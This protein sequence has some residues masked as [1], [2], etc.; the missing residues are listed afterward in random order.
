M[1]ATA[2][3]RQRVRPDIVHIPDGFLDAKT[4]LASA[5]LSCAGLSLAVRAVQ[6]RLPPARVPLL[7]LSTAF[8]FAAQMVNFPVVGGTSGHLLG[9]VLVTVLLGP[10][11][12]VLVMSAVLIL[13]C[14]L[15]ADGGLTALGA[16]LFNMALVAP[17]VGHGVNR[18][19][20][21]L[22]G[23]GLRARLFAAAF[24]A[25]C[26]T[27]AAAISCA[28]QLAMSGT[29]PWRATFPAMALIHML[30]GAGEAI[31]TALVLSGLARARP[32]L[33]TSAA[34]T[35]GG[36]RS[37]VA[38]GLLGSIG[39][40]VFVAPF[41]CPWP[42]GL[43]KVAAVLGFEH[44]AAER[45]ILS[46][47]LPNYTVPGLASQGGGTVIA[48]GVGTLAAFALTWW[49]ARRLTRGQRGTV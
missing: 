27:V 8:V 6:R 35:P 28:G 45:P 23:T 18:S 33:L 19:V 16:N 24:A 39:L 22:W 48:G 7:G 42:D 32:E 47:P 34:E 25:W 13:Q 14:L 49:L 36:S 11:A 1:T 31:I 17:L 37:F 43:E 41:A 20:L 15:F 46:A 10:A 4:A 44:Q 12:A 38:L 3:T 9:A 40:A 30:I 26:A 2:P 5:A 29:A 21:R